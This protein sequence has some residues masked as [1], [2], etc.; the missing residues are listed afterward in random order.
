MRASRTGQ[1]RASGTVVL[2]VDDDRD[3]AESI[4]DVLR[5]RGRQVAV[6]LDGQSALALAKAHAQAIALILLDWR[7]PDS[8]AG[9]VLV[10]RLR[11][12]CGAGVPVVVLSADPTS[13]TEARLAQVNDYLPKP[14]EVDDL[15]DL[16]EN[17][18]D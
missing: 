1:E 10:R 3:I 9:A 14:F 2:I 17:L 5:A 8:L 7:L 13:L 11:E 12:T 6:A 16:V 18:C 4:A 15:L